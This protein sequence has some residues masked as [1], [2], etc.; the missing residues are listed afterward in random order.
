MKRSVRYLR[1]RMQKMLESILEIGVKDCILNST[2][3]LAS[4]VVYYCCC[5]LDIRFHRLCCCGQ[6]DVVNAVPVPVDG[7]NS[8]DADD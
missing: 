8:E 4:M 5:I 6:G 1:A 7:V 3:S 2:S